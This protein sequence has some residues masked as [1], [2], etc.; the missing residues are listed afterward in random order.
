MLGSGLAITLISLYLWVLFRFG[1]NLQPSL[2]GALGVC[3]SL[4]L[5]PYLWAYDQILL[6]VPIL[7]IIDEL[8]VR[9]FPY[10]LCASF[11]ILMSGFSLAL[12]LVALK[13]SYDVWSGLLSLV[14]LLLLIFVCVSGF[15]PGVFIETQSEI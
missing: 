12:I 2:V 6:I 7:V 14:S 5:T 1:K 3:V 11:P 8:V 9:D 15:R 4:L 13:I 10:L